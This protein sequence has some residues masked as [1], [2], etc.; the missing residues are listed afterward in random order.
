M[1]FILTAGE[2]HCGIK[3]KA[4]GRVNIFWVEI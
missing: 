2:W 1:S 3:M 4:E